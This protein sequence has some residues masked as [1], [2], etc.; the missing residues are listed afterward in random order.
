M[1]I[2][3]YTRLAEAQWNPEEVDAF[4]RDRGYHIGPQGLSVGLG[5]NEEGEPSVTVAVDLD[6]HVPDDDLAADL[7]AFTPTVDPRATAQ[8]QLR[9]ALAA[10]R[11]A[12]DQTTTEERIALHE[13]VILAYAA[14]LGV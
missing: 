9:V 14:T 1:A 11:G 10:L 12:N 7:D 8:V 4:L 2:K 6:P 5:T 3:T 13:A